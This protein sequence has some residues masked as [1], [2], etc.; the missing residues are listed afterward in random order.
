M[1]LIKD[2]PKKDIFVLLYYSDGLLDS[3]APGDYVSISSR[4]V[5]FQAGVME[6]RVSVQT[7]TDTISED[8][9]RFTAI[10]SSPNGT[11]L[12]VSEATVNITDNS[13]VI[14]EFDPV[15]YSVSES[16]N[17]VTFMIRKRTQTTRTVE[18]TFMTE[19]I[20]AQG[21]VTY[22]NNITMEP[23]IQVLK[24]SPYSKTTSL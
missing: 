8:T 12:G 23:V 18:V 6:Q 9:E 13:N 17:L 20:T 19:S 2:S 16:A 7:S 15:A 24:R 14:V 4:T 21:S 11:V 5:S 22:T 3:L 10:L 1:N